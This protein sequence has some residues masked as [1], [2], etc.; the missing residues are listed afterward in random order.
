MKTDR[1]GNEILTADFHNDYY[2][3]QF[4]N[5]EITSVVDFSQTTES[6]YVTYRYNDKK[7]TCRFS[8]HICN[9]VEF[10]DQLD[11]NFATKNEILY[12]LGLVERVFIPET[13]LSITK[14]CVKKSEISN[15]EECELTIQD[16]YDLGANADI[17][18]CTGK[19]AKGSNYLIQGK[20]VEL[21]EK[22]GINRLGQSITY[23]KYIYK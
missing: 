2:V 14:Q 10:G 3:E 17:S 21:C 8:N 16:M 22:R 23:G 6:V 4:E 1:M 18:K 19:I 9:A 15:Y 13:F 7:I 20:T 5:T 12:K 11:G